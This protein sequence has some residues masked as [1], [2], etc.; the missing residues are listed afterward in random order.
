MRDSE[1][2]APKYCLRD[3]MLLLFGICMNFAVIL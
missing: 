2:T 3:F 1:W